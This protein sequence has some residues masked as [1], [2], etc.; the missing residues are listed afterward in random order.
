VRSFRDY[1]RN[2][3]HQLTPE[4]KRRRLRQLART[5]PSLRLVDITV[6]YPLP[7]SSPSTS[8]SPIY[9]SDFY[10]LPS[11]LLS[12]IAPP[13]LHMHIR[14]FSLSE[15]P[16][17]ELDAV[18]AADGEGTEDEKRAFERWLYDRWAEKDALLEQFRTRG[19]FVAGGVGVGV[20]KRG[21]RGNG[22]GGNGATSATRS[23]GIH[24]SS[25]D[26]DDDSDDEER[27]GEYRWPVSLRQPSW[28]I[29]AAFQF[30]WPFL[31]AYLLW[32]R[33]RDIFAS[34]VSILLWVFVR[35]AGDGQVQSIG[36][37]D[38]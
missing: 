14:A 17:G 29:P 9:A 37:T 15:I 10:T 19:T 16:L 11:V 3:A 5:T 6:G 1:R 23:H 13:E 21:E 12:H 8:A 26:D 27:R 20:G 30:G 34:I 35:L 25:D 18:D 32:T 36:K 33:R 24:A 31:V 28:E 38:L 2:C 22:S 7:R 4:R